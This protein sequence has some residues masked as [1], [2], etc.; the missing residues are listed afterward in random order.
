MVA[1]S[2]AIQRKVALQGLVQTR[3]IYKD[4]VEAKM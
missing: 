2:G 1:A 3:L 4:M